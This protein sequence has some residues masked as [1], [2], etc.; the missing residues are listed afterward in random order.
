ML[1]QASPYSEG[2]DEVV[3]E[4]WVMLVD[5]KAWM[6]R[7]SHGTQTLPSAANGPIE[8]LWVAPRLRW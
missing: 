3:M 7:F 4:A 5:G 6:A 1:E 2:L 8:C